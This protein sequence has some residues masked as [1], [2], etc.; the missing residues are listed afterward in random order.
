M[1]QDRINFLTPAKGKCTKL[2][3]TVLSVVVY[4]TAFSEM[5]SKFFLCRLFWVGWVWRKMIQPI[6]S[7]AI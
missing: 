2:N 4:V 3:N 5:A 6:L 1:S 7:K